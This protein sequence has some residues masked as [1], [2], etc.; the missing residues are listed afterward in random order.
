MAAPDRAGKTARRSAPLQAKKARQDNPAAG[1]EDV[2]RDWGSLTSG[3][4]QR[5]D[6]VTEWRWLMSVWHLADMARCLT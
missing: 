3:R 6:A 5:A 2:L 4:G 1:P